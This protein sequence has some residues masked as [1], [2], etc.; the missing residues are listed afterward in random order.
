MALPCA[1]ALAQANS[2]EKL[3]AVIDPSQ[4]DLFERSALPY[5]LWCYKKSER[6][7][8]Y[9]RLKQEKT[10][11]AYL[12]TNS[13]GSYL[14]YWKARVPTRIGF[15][16]KWTRN[17]LTH[18]V[19][20]EWQDLP[21]A[22]RWLKL[23]DPKLDCMY[24][25]PL[26]NIKTSV[27]QPPHLLVFPGAKYG[28]AKQWDVESYATV[29]QSALTSQWKVSLLGTLA[30]I[31]I[32]HQIAQAIN[33][34]LELLFGT[35]DLKELLD[36]VETLDNPIALANDSGAMHLMSASGVPTLGLY[37]STSALNTPPAFGTY[38]VL[39]ADIPCRPCYKR[40]CPLHHYQCRTTLKSDSVWSNLVEL[41][42]PS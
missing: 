31:E 35:H 8:L 33:M 36:Y 32:G 34:P 9:K 24:V 41:S 10:D 27:A 42:R 15:G 17:L 22:Q 18:P 21:Q 11:V 12:L 26:L 29:I 7:Q 28:P 16:G 37:F 39:E 6:D 5:E 23:I 14:P 19:K 13:L 3:I 30:E 38:R 1:K 40:S 2:H 20:N 4:R 25:D